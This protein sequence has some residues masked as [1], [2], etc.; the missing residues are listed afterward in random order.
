MKNSIKK[1]L[2]AYMTFMLSFTLFVPS[3]FAYDGN[4]KATYAQLLSYANVDVLKAY[5]YK[6]QNIAIG[7]AAAI[8]MLLLVLLLFLI[9]TSTVISDV[10]IHIT[11]LFAGSII[12]HARQLSPPSICVCIFT[13]SSAFRF[14]LWGFYFSGE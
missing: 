6:N 9:V 12:A 8:I 4:F 10:R 2:S 3:A 11:E 7:V 13:V 1:F 14:R 5:L